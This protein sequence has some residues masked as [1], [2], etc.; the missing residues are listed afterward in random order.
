M[1]APSGRRG[2]TLVEM[3]V[4]VL[5]IALLAGITLPSAT[6]GLES[7]RL[8]AAADATAGFIN[9]A[10]NRAERRQHLVEISVN[11]V[12][13]TLW[14]R[15]TESGFNDRMEIPDGVQIVA[16]LPALAGDDQV[17]LRRFLIYPGG[18]VPRFGIQL[19]ARNGA[20]R[21]V[22]VDPLTGVPQIEVIPN[23]K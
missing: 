17:P 18:T 9:R 22:R 23:A 14:M 20:Q 6:S 19:L 8:R 2:V 11:K 12:D 10:L 3:L 7:L 4:V 5:L 13:N 15:S 21:I 16:V 1:R